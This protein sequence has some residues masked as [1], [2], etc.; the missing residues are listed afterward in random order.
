MS[1]S[2]TALQLASWRGHW[3]IVQELMT[4]GLSVHASNN[5]GLTAIHLAANKG[6]V[7]VVQQLLALG[8]KVDVTDHYGTTPLHYAASQKRVDVVKVLLAHGAFVNAGGG[9]PLHLA[10]ESDYVDIVKE[11]DPS[12]KTTKKTHKGPVASVNDQLEVLQLLL[13]AR[14]KR[15]LRNEEGK[16]ARD[17]ANNDV[18]AWFDNYQEIAHQQLLKRISNIPTRPLQVDQTV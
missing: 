1:D 10:S 6:H 8:V 5:V 13:D 3:D 17:L 11:N 14:A 18:Q 16:T 2:N 4:H 9:T 12:V 15:L 7:E